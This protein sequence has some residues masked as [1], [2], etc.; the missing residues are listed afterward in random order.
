[1]KFSYLIIFLA[2]TAIVIFLSSCAKYQ[3]VSFEKTLFEKVYVERNNKGD[4]I[5]SF[6][7]GS[8]FEE[9]EV[10]KGTQ[11]DKID[12]STPIAAGKENPL[13]LT[14]YDFSDRYFFGIKNK[15]GQK[16]VASERL[17]PMENA[18][19][20]RDLGGIP[21]KDGRIV[22]WGTFYR[23]GKLSELSSKDLQYFQT[24]GIKTVIDFRDDQEI[25]EDPNRYPENYVVERVRTPIG[26]RSGNMQRELRKTIKKANPDN[27]D[28]EKFVADVMRQFVDTFAFQY[29]PFLE[30]ASNPEK[31]PLL[32]HCTAGKDR[33]GLGSALILA[34]LGVERE[35]IFGDYLMS[36]YY[37]NKKINKSLR[38]ATLVGVD[39]RIA[40][41]LVEVKSSY[42]AAA[43]E[44]MDK[45]YG[46][47]EN[48]LNVEYGLDEV[49]LAAIRNQFL[50]S[51]DNN[52]ET[53]QE[54]VE[55]LEENKN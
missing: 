19:N 53:V 12:W 36:N 13:V 40:Q 50:M 42:I 23:S 9:Y 26:D 33:T 38:K 24:L 51:N 3:K 20:F 34:M 10:Y 25:K 8:D 30:F 54:T 39:Q 21:T 35:V 45:K 4:Y 48:F 18:L 44:A 32:F 55:I 27:F 37:R 11:P 41:P 29:K 5:L 31:T 46:S 17:I 14:T 16:V 15:E 22:K 47:V 1:M 52:V 6:A 43:F 7:T 2:I 28:S 49:K